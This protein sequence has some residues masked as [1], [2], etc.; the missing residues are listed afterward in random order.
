[1]TETEIMETSLKTR[2][3]K[4]AS[5]F[6]GSAMNAPRARCTTGRLAHAV[7]PHPESHQDAL[8][9]LGTSFVSARL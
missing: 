4:V 5:S 8:V 7:E 9:V 2:H 1:M 3:Y 6:G